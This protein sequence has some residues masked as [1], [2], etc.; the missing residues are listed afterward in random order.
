MN[1]SKQTNLTHYVQFIASNNNPLTAT[2]TAY[3]EKQITFLDFI[4]MVK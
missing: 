1:G 3:D 4:M 2:K